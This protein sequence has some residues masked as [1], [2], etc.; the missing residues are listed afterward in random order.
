MTFLHRLFSRGLEGRRRSSTEASSTRATARVL[1]LPQY[2]ALVTSLTMPTLL[3]MQQFAEFVAGA[4]SW[5]KHLPL[6]PPG[7]PLQF[8]L[9][10]AAGMQLV[11]KSGGIVE[12]T[13]RIERG[14]HYSWLPTTEYRDRFGYLAFSRS[15]GTSVSLLLRD[16]SQL[17]ESDD[18]ASV[19]DFTIRTACQLPEEVIQAGGAFIS[20]IVHTLGAD[21]RLW[22]RVIDRNPRLDWPEESGGL[23]T[24]AKIRDRCR[25]LREDPSR[26]ERLKPKDLDPGQDPNLVMVDLPLYRILEPER[27]RQRAGMVAAMRRVVDLAI[28]DS[29]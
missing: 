26:L 19:F 15:S 2:R 6:L 27:Q 11:A 5:Y 21:H 1:T 7:Q 9:D 28:T 17:I 29:A 20:G 4:H 24:V 14:F 10:P 3:Q 8:F 16:G 25:V 22:Q 12:A 18:V 23:E 13:P